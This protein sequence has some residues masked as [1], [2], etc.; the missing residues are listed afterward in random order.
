MEVRS[1]DRA[2]LVLPA[3]SKYSVQMA[4]EN[5]DWGYRRILGELSNLGQK[6]ARGTIANILKQDGIEPHSSGVVNHSERVSL[7]TLGSDSGGGFLYR[8]KLDVARVAA[9]H[10]IVLH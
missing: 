3:R 4:L 10:C 2:G 1:V 9:L 8:E 7:P 5:R 6:V